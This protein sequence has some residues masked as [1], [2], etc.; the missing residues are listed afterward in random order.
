MTDSG[1]ANELLLP[2]PTDTCGACGNRVMDKAK[3]DCF[4]KQCHREMRSRIEA[5]KK[6][7][8]AVPGHKVIVRVDE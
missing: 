6:L 7:L 4:Y 2:K 1:R 3:E 5:A 8:N